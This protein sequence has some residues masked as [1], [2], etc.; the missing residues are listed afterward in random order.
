MALGL[1][2]GYVQ[3]AGTEA[4]V[5]G[6]EDDQRGRK[7]VSD[8]YHHLWDSQGLTGLHWSRWVGGSLVIGKGPEAQIWD[9]AWSEERGGW[10]RV[11]NSEQ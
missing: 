7:R 4:Q 8:I 2:N 3:S 6:S 9:G 1:A 10:Y 11:L 5:W